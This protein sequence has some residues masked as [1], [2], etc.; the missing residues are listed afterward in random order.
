MLTLAWPWLLIL[1]PLPFII[2]KKSRSTESGGHLHLTG[3][4]PLSVQ[5]SPLKQNLTRKRYWLMWALLILSISR[6]LWLGDPID[7]PTKGRDL[8]LSVD[9][10]G[11]MQIEDMKVNGQNVDRFTLVQHVLSHFIE[12]RKGD[13]IGL[14]LFADHA[15]LQS[16]L[17]LDRRSVTQFLIEAQIGLVGKQTA[18]GEAI[19]LAVKRFDKVDKSNRVLI[20]LTDGSNNAGTISPD[21]AA[22]IAAKRG[23]TIYTIGVGAD[24]MERRTIFGKERIN[25]SMDLDEVQ[26]KSIASTTH[27]RYFRAR[28]PEELEQIY[29]EIDKLEPISRD[30][31]TYRPQ[32]E[33]FYWPL[34]FALLM[35]IVLALGYLPWFNRLT[36]QKDS[37][38][39]TAPEGKL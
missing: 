5:A 13:R 24:V 28:S 39:H 1:L 27:G 14:I 35:S 2:R 20:L 4:E 23:I 6:P 15:Y 31:L 18:I 11:S 32:L 37:N 26:L 33:L 12:R 3:I 22:A 21:K 25:P 29:Q 9:L 17:T 8:M 30:Q 19:A 36:F 10:S 7:L 16:P 38:K 34:G